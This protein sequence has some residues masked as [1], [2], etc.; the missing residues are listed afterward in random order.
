[1]CRAGGRRALGSAHRTKGQRAP[2]RS[3]TL[4]RHGPTTRGGSCLAASRPWRADWPS[5]STPDGS[6]VGRR[7]TRR[8]ACPPASQDAAVQRGP[9]LLDS[10]PRIAPA[11]LLVRL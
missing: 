3:R 8:D 9:L 5:A 10:V 11:A 1:S 4:A 2:R 7:R 6:P